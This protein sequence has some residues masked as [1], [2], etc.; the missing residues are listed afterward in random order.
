MDSNLVV[1]E[2]TYQHTGLGGIFDTILSCTLYRDTSKQSMIFE[3]L[4][5][6][7]YF[8]TQYR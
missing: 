4:V 1:L 8:S 6:G 2:D 7:N 3:Y 5:L